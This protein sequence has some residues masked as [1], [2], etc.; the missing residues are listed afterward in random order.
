MLFGCFTSP[1]FPKTIS[2]LFSVNTEKN[3]V[4]ILMERNAM[5]NKD[6]RGEMSAVTTNWRLHLY[7]VCYIKRDSTCLG[8]E[9]TITVKTQIKLKI[10]SVMG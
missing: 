10:N 6:Y 5:N 3:G 9:F 1:I 7:K 2:P 8:Q 4:C